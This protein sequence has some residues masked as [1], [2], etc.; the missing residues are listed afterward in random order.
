MIKILLK[1]YRRSIKQWYH[2][3]MWKYSSRYRKAWEEE[4]QLAFYFNE[5]NRHLFERLNVS[6]YIRFKDIDEDTVMD[7]MA[8]LQYDHENGPEYE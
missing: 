5:E 3:I 6:G 7:E 2:N 4:E 8:K 1:L